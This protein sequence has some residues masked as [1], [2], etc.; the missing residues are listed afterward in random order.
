MEIFRLLCH[1]DHLIRTKSTGTPSD[2]ARK[3]SI[4]RRTLY[5]YL[6]IMRELGAPVRY[7]RGMQSYEYAPEGRLLLTFNR[8]YN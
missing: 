8:E 6:E 7:A 4:S 1:M 2:F 5:N 3:L